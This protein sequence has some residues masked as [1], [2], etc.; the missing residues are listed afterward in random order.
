MKR[1][2]N[3]ELLR[4]LTMIGV[5]IL[6]YNNKSIGGGLQ[7]VTHSSTNY[8]ILMSLESLCICAVDL[9]ILISGYFSSKSKKTT[10]WKP[11]QLLVQLECMSLGIY[12]ARTIIKGGFSVSGLIGSLIPANYFVVLYIMVYLLSPYLN[13]LIEKCD[14]KLLIIAFIGFSVYPQCVD[15]FCQL[16]NHDFYGLSTIGIYGSQ[17]GYNIVNF[18]LLY[19]VGGYL[20]KYEERITSIKSSRIG[21]VLIT[22][23]ALITIWSILSDYYID[24]RNLVFSYHNPLVIIEA[25][26]IFILFL[27][28]NIGYRGWINY[29]A[30][31]SFT[32]FLVHGLFITHIGIDK[33]VNKPVIILLGHIALSSVSI[34]LLCFIVF[35]AYDFIVGR[36]FK[37]RKGLIVTEL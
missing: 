25:A 30:K 1:E 16:T 10:L 29:L 21:V 8:Y 22:A 34:Y 31:A 12:L 17:W 11:I 4:I 36:W 5:I 7:F 32:T 18:I 37:G 33:F 13:L 26:V 14:N 20:R 35:V 3:I 15:V 19:I 6:H 27:R 28:I 23:V 9:F 24:G 2:S